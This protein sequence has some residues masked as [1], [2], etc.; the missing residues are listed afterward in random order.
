[1][2]RHNALLCGVAAVTAA[3]SKKKRGS[4][5]VRS[6]ELLATLEEDLGHLAL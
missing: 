1:M 4:A 6:R 5:T 2:K 3:C